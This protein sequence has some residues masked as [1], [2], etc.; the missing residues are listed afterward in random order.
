MG[1]ILSGR[2]MLWRVWS[3]PCG[4]AVHRG[5]LRPLGWRRIPGLERCG[6]LSVGLDRRPCGAAPELLLPVAIAEFYH[7]MTLGSALKLGETMDN[8]R[9]QAVLEQI[10]NGAT[11]DSEETQTLD[12]KCVGR[13]RSDFFKVLARSAACFAN[14]EGGV[15]IIGVRDSVAGPDAFDG[16]DLDNSEIVSRIYGLTEPSLVV[17]AEELEFEGHR[18]TKIL[19]P[20]SPDIHQV[21]GVA[22]ERIGSECQAMSASRIA[23]VQQD[24]RGDDWSV[25]D[26]GIPMEDASPVAIEL[27]REMIRQSSDSERRAW[28]DLG[29]SDLCRRLGVS[30]EGNLTNGGAMLFCDGGEVHVHYTRRVQT[31]GLLSANEQVSGPG[32]WALR[33]TLELIDTR[34]DRTAII[35]PGGTQLFIGDLPEGAVREAVV[36]AVMHRDYRDSAPIQVEHGDGTLR[37]TSPGGFV[38]GVTLDNVLTVSSRSR[39]KSLVD[40]IRGLGLGEAAGVGVDRM[41]AAMTAIGHGPPTFSTDG[42]HVEIVFNGGPPNEPVTRFV[43][44]LPEN[45]RNNPDVLLTIMYL[46]TNRIATAKKMSKLMQKSEREAEDILMQLSASGAPLLERTA[47]TAR[48]RRGE[49]R[50]VGAAVRS[51]GVAVR[52]R[53]RSGD[54]TDRKIIEMVREAGSITGRMVQTMFDVTPTTA[55]RILSDLVDRRILRKTSKAQRGPS[56]TYGPDLKFPERKRGAKARK[57]SEEQGEFPL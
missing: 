18:L 49:Y 48:S 15:L 41:Y 31:A 37:V 16:S 14:S 36:N 30:S 29:W 32:L 38:S 10:S 55:S 54:D 21:S 35:L 6:R 34:I 24:R 9:I 28:A 5:S 57:L 50:L 51:L 7:E 19:V 17:I 8:E 4:N 52:Y 13:S 1:A 47:D 56:V 42:E 12:F 33:R 26:S 22:P 25:K 39:N 20:S 46:L 11:A 45:Q 3:S 40:A 44:G 2:A 53:A 23:A 43:A 27:A